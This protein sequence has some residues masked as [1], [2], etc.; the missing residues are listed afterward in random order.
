MNGLRTG[1]ALAVAAL[2]WVL[3][4]SA[5]QAPGSG[6]PPPA[7]STGSQPASAAP[8]NTAPAAAAPQAATTGPPAATR[9]APL[10]P[11]VPMKVGSIGVAAEAGSF[12]ALERGYYREEG[13]DLD[14]TLLSG[15]MADQ[16][17]LLLTGELS[18]AVGAFE[19]AI[20]NAASRDIGVR[21]IAP[22]SYIQP[23]DRNAAILVRQDLLA[24]GRYK[25]PA[26]LR[27]MS[28]GV[29]PRLGTSAQLFVDQALAKGGL[30]P[31]DAEL[32]AINFPDTLPALGNA[33]LDVVWVPEPFVTLAVEQRVAQP[34]LYA[35]ELYPNYDTLVYAV[36]PVFAASQPEAAKRFV[37]ALLRGQRDYHRAF[38]QNEGSKDEIVQF[39]VGHTAI[40]DPA[41]YARMN[42]H[43]VEPNGAFHLPALETSLDYFVAQGTLQRKLELS[44]MIDRTYMDYALQQLGR[45]P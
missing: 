3:A 44:Q 7:T 12:V 16:L 13:L 33:K 22:L 14:M 9:A 37:K 31:T 10:S 34:V 32:E 4:L 20:I 6:S 19:P 30:K 39:L 26:D 11:A 42:L 17:P 5:C 8:A 38:Q 35:G 24:S 36:S 27:G 21:V 1:V 29:G 15:G 28:I 18:V 43:S 25:T 45:L 41:L 40:K 2:C 23:S